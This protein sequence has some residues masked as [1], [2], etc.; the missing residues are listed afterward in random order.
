MFG[1]IAEAPDIQENVLRFLRQLS[2]A[3]IQEEDVIDLLLE[4]TSSLL[5][6]EEKREEVLMEHREL[7]SLRNCETLVVDDNQ[8]IAFI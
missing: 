6:I 8:Q 7:P 3:E 2:E 5:L 4:T 1:L